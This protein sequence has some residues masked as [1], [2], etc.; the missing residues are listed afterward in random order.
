MRVELDTT[1]AQQYKSASQ[2]A[3]VVTEAWVNESVFCPNCGC[4]DLVKYGNNQPVADFYCNDCHEDYELKS[5]G[6]PI[7]NRISDGAYQAKITRLTQSTNPNLFLLRYDW[8]LACVVDF[9]VIPKYYFVPSIIEQRKPLSPAARR[10][11]WEGSNILVSTIPQSGR[12]FYV[13]DKLVKPKEAV[14]AEFRKT[15][16]LRE[17]KKLDAKGWLL[18]T[19]RCIEKLGKGRFT[20]E[21]AYGFEDELHVLHPENKHIKAKIRQ[22]LQVLRDERYLDFL[23]GGH[24]KVR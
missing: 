15:I 11:G 22:Q 21:D 2:R 13:H 17:Q 6:G 9:L 14:L 1:I 23:G 3:R 20:I 4:P 18:D 10:A 16:F 8:A 19:M 12:I 24:Y 5:K 7:G